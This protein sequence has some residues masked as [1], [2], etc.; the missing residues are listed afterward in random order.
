MV[1]IVAFTQG[2]KRRWSTEQMVC[3]EG[4]RVW[5]GGRDKGV[6]MGC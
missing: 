6:L 5:V 4:V 3:E 1:N 2:F